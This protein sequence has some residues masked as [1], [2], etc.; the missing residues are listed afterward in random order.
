MEH[1]RLKNN[2]RENNF[3]FFFPEHMFSSHYLFELPPFRISDPGSNSRHLSPHHK[4]RRVPSL[5]SREECRN[6]LELLN[7]NVYKKAIDQVSVIALP[8]RHTD[9]GAAARD[10][11]ANNREKCGRP[12]LAIRRFPARRPRSSSLLVFPALR[13]SPLEIRRKGWNLS[14]RDLGLA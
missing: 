4:V 8:Q 11:S 13:F 1:G 14:T 12:V 3:F 5:L 10:Q 7:E 2:L 6:F 9:R